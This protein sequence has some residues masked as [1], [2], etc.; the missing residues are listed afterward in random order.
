LYHRDNEN[1]DVLGWD[2]AQ[3]G[4]HD[5]S[6]I[7]AQQLFRRSGSLVSSNSVVLC[8][9]LFPALFISGGGIVVGMESRSEELAWA[10]R[11][12]GRYVEVCRALLPPRERFGGKFP[13]SELRDGG[14]RFHTRYV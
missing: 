14:K 7:V 2:A 6:G 10:G 4:A 13:L 12:T 8:R 11:C 1:T 3:S 5:T 9:C